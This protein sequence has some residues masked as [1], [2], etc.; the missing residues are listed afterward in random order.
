MPCKQGV[1]E[2]KS[3]DRKIGATISLHE[4]EVILAWI[5]DWVVLSKTR[6]LRTVEWASRE[7]VESK[8]G[9][10]QGKPE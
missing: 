5:V 8:I 2:D 3:K 9:D 6:V 7:I 4:R 1:T 10:L